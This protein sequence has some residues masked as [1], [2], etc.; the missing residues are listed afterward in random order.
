MTDHLVRV[1][2]ARVNT[3]VYISA[4]ESSVGFGA[5]WDQ[6]DT[7]I[8]PV[9]GAKRWT[10]F[11]PSVLSAQQPWTERATSGRS[12]WSE[13]IEPGDA[14]V[15]PRGWGHRV[16]NLD[17][18]SVHYTIGVN[19][20]EVHQIFDR[21]AF[22]SGYWP[23]YRADVP[24]DPFAPI[25]SYG[26]SVFDEPLGLA[27]TL[28]EIATPA[29]VHRAVASYRA[30]LR[31][32]PVQTLSPAFSAVFRGAWDGLC[33]R[34]VA[35]GGVM[36]VEQDED[37]VVVAFDDRVVQVDRVAWPAFLTLASGGAPA[38]ADLPAIEV[39]GLDQREAFARQLIVARMAVVE[40]G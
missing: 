15:I 28:S 25:D 21:I 11:E 36:L 34:L 14:L 3:N 40:S 37:H 16:E 5:H 24:F 19:R 31:V 35:P 12:I 2:G 38:V 6:H 27:E 23:A 32:D 29:L 8:V 39:D 18:L 9:Q 4:G 1:S 30:R 17:D 7:I 33:L 10:I 13:I 26:G 20:F 22:E